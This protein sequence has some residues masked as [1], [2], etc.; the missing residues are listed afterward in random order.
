MSDYTL[1]LQKLSTGFIMKAHGDDV[2][3]REF[4]SW[5]EVVPLLKG[6]LK[7]DD[8]EVEWV[9]REL[10]KASYGVP[11]FQGRR[12]VTREVVDALGLR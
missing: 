10:E 11:L 6:V 1:T 7:A 3:R 8:N 9:R 5:T 12:T 4:A 2:P